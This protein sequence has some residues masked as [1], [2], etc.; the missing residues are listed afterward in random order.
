MKTFTVF[1]AVFNGGMTIDRVYNSLLRQSFTDFEWLVIDD[2]STDNTAALVRSMMEESK[3]QIR[4][5]QQKNM[6]QFYSILKGI[7]WAEG[8]YF[9]LADADDEFREDSLLQLYNAFESIPLNEQINLLGVNCLCRNGNNQLIGDP[10]PRNRMISD[11]NEMRFK[12]NVKGEKWGMQRVDILRKFTFPSEYFNNGYIPQSVLWSKI[13]GEGYKI[14]FIN[15][16]LRL[17]HNEKDR[18]SISTNAVTNLKTNSF[19]SMQTLKGEINDQL[20]YFR[21]NPLYFLKIAMLYFEASKLQNINSF[22]QAQVLNSKAK[23]LYWIT[24]PFSLLFFLYRKIT[25]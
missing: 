19:G 1:T 14:L 13:A 18:I 15:E 21:Y 2:G 8:K 3:I 7:E 25:T 20:K 9:L 11:H 10:Y 23:L 4:L 12:Y 17:Y 22:Q 24:Y 6:H 5:F 16:T